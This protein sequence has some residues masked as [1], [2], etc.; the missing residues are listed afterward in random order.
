LKKIF[1][2]FLILLIL[3]IVAVVSAVN[4]SIVI[5]KIA[6]R[7]AP[8]YNLSYEH[9]SGNVFTGIRIDKL[10]YD[11]QTIANDIIYKWDPISL[12]QKKIS[13]NE[14]KIEDADI[15]VIKALIA[16]FDVDDSDDNSSEPFSFDIGVDNISISLNPF[17]EEGITFY[18]TI[19]TAD[20]VTYFQ[21]GTIAVKNVLL[22]VDSNLTKFSFK[23]SMRENKLI[24][25]TLSIESLNS[26]MLE[27]IIAH[28]A[29]VSGATKT[30]E[31]SNS[32]RSLNPMIPKIVTLEHFNGS[33]QPRVY[34]DMQIEKLD[35]I[36]DDVKVD[37]EKIVNN[38]KES[39][40]IGNIEL[41][42]ESNVTDIELK[43]KLKEDKAFFEHLI[44]KNV[45]SL[46][47][48][49]IFMNED[50]ETAISA[51]STEEKTVQKKP[52]AMIPQVI[53]IKKLQTNILPLDYD[54]VNIQQ[55]VLNAEDITLDVEKLLLK[56]ANIDLNGTSNLTNLFY[57]GQI[58][59]NHL[60]GEIHLTPN[61][62][63]FELYKLPLR[64]EAIGTI[65]VDFNASKEWVKAELKA[66]AK[67]VLKG[68]KGEFNIDIDNLNSK[69]VYTI[70]S[71]VLI[72]DSKIMVTTPYAKDIALTNYFE[73]DKNISY[74]GEIKAKSLRGIEAKFTKPLED[75]RITYSGDEKSIHT[76][77]FAKQLKGSFDSKEFKTGVLHLETTDA[78]RLSE[79]VA[80]PEALNDTKLNAIVDAPLDF[81]KIIP[82]Q[83]KVKIDSN[84]IN[85]NADLLYG[86][87]L[88]LKAKTILPNDSLLKTLNA[89][90]K[91]EGLFPLNLVVDMA[92]KSATVKLA[93]NILHANTKYNFSNTKING[94]IK[95]GGLVTNISGT[96]K[97]KI[98]ID[99]KINSMKSL[100]KSIVKLY[101]LE[102]F[103]PL[104]GG[105]N[106]SVTVTDLKKVDIAL[107]SQKLVYKADR[108]TKHVL[109]DLKVTANFER[110]NVVLKTY[111]LNYNKQKFF[112]TKPSRVNINNDMITIESIWLNDALHISGNY[113]LKTKQG[114]IVAKANKFPLRHEYAD[115]DTML[116]LQ[117]QLD[118]NRTSVNGKVTLLGGK[119]KY[120]ISKKTFASDSD[121]IIV[122]EMKKKK[123]SPFMDNLSTNIQVDTKE[124][125]VLK[126]GAINIKLKPE[127]GINKVEH[128]PLMVLGSVELLKGGSYVFEG[129]RFVLDKSFVHFTG[130]PNKPLLEI[131]VKYK[132]I[133]HLITINVSGT[134]DAPN[135][136]FSSSPSLTKEQ[137]LS[138][139]LFDS[140][141]GGDT[142]SGDE[143]MKMM[144]GAM[145]K[146]ALSDM[147]IKLD[148][149]VLGEG[150][151]V[152]VG[153]KLT[154]K[155]TIIYVNDTVSSVKL[156]YQHSRR[157]ESVL[158]M[159]E[160]S[161]SY[162]II[163]KDDF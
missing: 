30:E 123:A 23:G 63:L 141:V 42:V 114:N 45:N 107:S 88:Q 119:I 52:N 67:H 13:I 149:L 81:K 125:L 65:V 64:K 115:I 21:N 117:T 135:I 9:I 71:N 147:G 8:D 163:F 140:E 94:Q 105:V 130:N 95:L 161:Q 124:P 10:K 129:K 60:T 48:Q 34:M 22:N 66:K 111:S 70:K 20:D 155:I 83:A 160:E 4:S 91:W 86:K 126:Q 101:K 47:L 106:L 57:Q 78:I 28:F 99:T 39:L 116:D 11:D 113:N 131:K 40:N 98:K 133:N 154:N 156:K 85:M 157:T 53:E 142:H 97:K 112:S 1:Y 80:L 100:E 146:S 87:T 73:M 89:D 68:K 37:I 144:G 36:V 19:L 29:D 31:T 110:S 74:K 58:R 137:I 139:I 159:S 102:D 108:K 136:N 26:Q 96:A 24:V 56:N 127:V 77:I 121:I 128:G 151:S 55:L 62:P 3:F 93:S 82:L 84:V 72:A 41:Q 162:D 152:E 33:L 27:K 75:L 138:V 143:M 109:N 25:D 150:N 120:D 134:P 43:A 104:E 153:K 44:L 158:E 148:H 51:I 5:D 12:L 15:A 49:K 122:Q 132:S 92:D 118:G 16:S 90:V 18:K 79:L 35:L 32:D 103:P 61:E 7:F 6:K 38:Q 76:Q 14:I 50:N 54:P 2:A 69:I 46:A 145:A 17:Q 59:N